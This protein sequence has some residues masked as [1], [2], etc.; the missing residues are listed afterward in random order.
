MKSSHLII[1]ILSVLLLCFAKTTYKRVYQVSSINKK[2]YLVRQTNDKKQ[3]K[4]ANLLAVLNEKKNKLCKF[5]E[6]SSEFKNHYGIKRLLQNKNF[7]LEEL[8]YEYDDQAAY[9]VNKGEKI[10]ICLR[11]KKGE[12][13]DENTMTF[14]LLHELAHIMSRKYAHDKEFWDNFALLLQAASRCGIYKHTNYEANP[15]TYCGH[16]ITHTPN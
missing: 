6:K 9:S 14:V 1:G 4:S 2:R 7:K 16:N 12:I 10:G 3:L 15:T 11:N 13:E 8:S 5:V